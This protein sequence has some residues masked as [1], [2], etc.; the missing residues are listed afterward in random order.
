MKGGLVVMLTALR[1]MKAAGTLDH[2][3]IRI[4]LA[5][6]R[7]GMAN[8][9]AS[10]RDMIDA[11]KKS[12]IARFDQADAP[13]GRTFR[14]S[15]GEVRAPRLETTRSGHSSQ[16]FGDRPVMAQST[17]L[18]GFWMH[19]ARNFASGALRTTSAW[20]LAARP[21]RSMM[22]GPGELQPARTT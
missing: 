13:T 1:A 2:P 10:R 14:A 6:M 12:D 19:F 20:C 16:I 7:N 11:A 9:F 8:R 21:R 18:C 5:V 17:S 3:E 4:V 22:M 15:A